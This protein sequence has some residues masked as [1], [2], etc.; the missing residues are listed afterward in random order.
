LKFHHFPRLEKSLWLPVEKCTNAHPLEKIL[1]TPMDASLRL[2][3]EI[4]LKRN[5][6]GMLQNKRNATLILLRMFG[7]GPPLLP[8]LPK[9]DLISLRL[10]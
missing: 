8:G 2:P 1:P 4:H 7:L 10:L 6:A 5:A 9:Q 3:T